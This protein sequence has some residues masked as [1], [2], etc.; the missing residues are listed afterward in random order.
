MG[1]GNTLAQQLAT[2]PDAPVDD[3]PP[4]PDADQA[5]IRRL[6]GGQLPAREALAHYEHLIQVLEDQVAEAYQTRDRKGVQL[7]RDIARIA[8]VARATAAPDGW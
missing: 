3:R 4:I 5:L 8:P 2:I 7:C 1:S 6:V